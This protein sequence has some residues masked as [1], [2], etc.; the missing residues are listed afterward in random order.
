MDPFNT[1]IT[2]KKPH[3]TQ[4][5]PLASNL[6][7]L[8][9]TLSDQ[10]MSDQNSPNKLF[11]EAL[12]RAGG[13]FGT[14]VESNKENS[15]PDHSST[16]DSSKNFDFS[17]ALLNNQNH[18]QEP[19]L[20]Q[21]LNS[22]EPEDQL[23]YQQEAKEKARKEALRKRLHDQVN[24][25]DS[26]A[27]FIAEEEKIRKQLEEIR[28]E[29]KALAKDIAELHREIDIAATQAI[30]SPGLEG[31]G[32]VSFFQKLKSFII[33]LRILL[34]QKVKSAQTW[35]QHANAKKAKQKRRIAAGIVIDGASHEQTKAV[36]DMMN[37]EVSGTYGND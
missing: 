9:K 27:V 21:S 13:N 6:V 24:P 32:Y 26:T 16:T 10:P 5:N 11:G 4:A 18:S 17:Q 1:N 20:A 7:E 8:E 25:V 23:P 34:R 3:S 2:S 14:W 22:Q 31:S 33:L 35:A 37:H 15:N 28:K 19:D 30:V 29:L 36:F 12:V